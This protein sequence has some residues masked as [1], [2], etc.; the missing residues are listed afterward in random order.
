MIVPRRGFLA[1]AGTGVLAPFGF[2]WSSVTATEDASTMYGLIGKM[3]AV[4][5]QRDALASILV[6]STQS[7]PGCLSYV[8]ATDAADAD[9]SGSL[10]CGTAQ[11]A[12]RLRWPCRPCRPPSRKRSR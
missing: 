6:G 4:A 8:I 9:R 2:P 5:G 7:M 10:K 1:M 12:I 3:T 11:R